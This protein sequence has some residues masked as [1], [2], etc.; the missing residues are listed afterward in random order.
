MR[1]PRKPRGATPVTVNSVPLR[2]TT[3]TRDVAAALEATLPA[4]VAQHDERIGALRRVARLEE[5]A[6]G[7]AHAEEGEEVLGHHLAPHHVA[8][9]GSRGCRG[10]EVERDAGHRGQV[11]EG[12]APVAIIEVVLVAEL[13]GRAGLRVGLEEGDEPLGRGG[14][15][16]P[17]EER[18]HVSDD[19]AV[20]ADADAEG[21]GDRE[22]E[23]GAPAHGAERVSDV[24]AEVVEPARAALVAHRFAVGVEPAEGGERAS[25]R[26]VRREAFAREPRGL[27]VYVEAKLLF[28][29]V[30][31]FARV[32]DR[33]QRGRW[34]P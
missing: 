23:P 24:G 2:R 6:R 22:G 7:R 15:D 5:A 31:G 12:A 26:F 16:R 18:V 10:R 19:D 33:A 14:G 21:D 4:L 1:S 8:C 9:P 29:A 3:P 25:P 20:D 30:F 27:H 32:Q 28:H 13:V 34:R 17:E 11:G